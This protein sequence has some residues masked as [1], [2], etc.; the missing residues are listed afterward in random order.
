[1]HKD[2]LYELVPGMMTE[3]LTMMITDT[4][5]FGNLNADNDKIIVH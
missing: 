1:M 2:V 5:D 4:L 3:S